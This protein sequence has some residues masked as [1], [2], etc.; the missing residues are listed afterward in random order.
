MCAQTIAEVDLKTKSPLFRFQILH[1]TPSCFGR[2]RIIH[3]K[4]VLQEGKGI[5]APTSPRSAFPQ[6][7]LKKSVINLNPVHAT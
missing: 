1:F 3:L 6:I 4:M 5:P 2:G 7:F